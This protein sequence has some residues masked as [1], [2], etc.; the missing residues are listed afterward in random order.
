MVQ[1]FSGALLMQ[2]SAE[3]SLWAAAYAQR[4]PT[5]AAP[6]S[7]HFSGPVASVQT[8]PASIANVVQNVAS[9]EMASVLDALD[10]LT[11]ELSAMAELNPKDRGDLINLNMT[12][13]QELR[14]PE[15][16]RITLKALFNGLSTFVQ[17]LAAT[18]ATYAFLE[19]AAQAVGLM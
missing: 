8:G 14:A 3:I 11:E 10:R 2:F 12:I 9:A 7:Y 19:S 16:N 15:P 17:T 4:T 13:G 6:S 5:G 1:T 18:P